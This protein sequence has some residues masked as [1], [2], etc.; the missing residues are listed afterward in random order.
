MIYETIVCTVNADG[1]P[2]IV[3]LGIRHQDDLILLAPFRPSA[4]LDNLQRTGSAVVSFTDD[5]RVFAGCLTGHYHWPTRPA[6]H[7][8]GFILKNALAHSELQLERLEDD[9]V[10]PRFYCRVVFSTSHAPF[11][12]FNR[13]QSAVIEAAILVSRLHMLPAEKIDQE[14]DYLSIAIEKTAGPHE[15]Q[16]WQWLMD[17]IASHRQAT[18]TTT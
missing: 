11:A 8:K 14:I 9:P 4:T 12:G 5:V 17:K 7:I 10:R 2:R 6:E 1:T 15:H 16:A 18:R 13:A 3:P